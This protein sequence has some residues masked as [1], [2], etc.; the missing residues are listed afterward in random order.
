M[1]LNYIL[2]VIST[3]TACTSCIHYYYAP[4]TNNVPLFKEKNEA[5]VAVQYV[6]TGGDV[7]LESAEGIEL[8]TAYA[9]SKNAAV[10]L[11]FLSAGTSNEDGS[12]SGTYIEAAGGYFKP[13]GKTKKFVF[14]TY[15]G[16]GLGGVNNLPSR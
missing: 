9:L 10:Q 2:V 4:N 16:F 13:F 1:K 14:E 7:N 3:V 11:N 15:A 6:E 12:G 8:Q 5:R